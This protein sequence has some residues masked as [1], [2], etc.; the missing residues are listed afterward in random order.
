MRRRAAVIAAG[1]C[2]AVSARAAPNLHVVAVVP[3]EAT[4]VAQDDAD[5]F[6]D[7]L[8]AELAASGTVSVADRRVMGALLAR[9]G[10]TATKLIDAERAAAFAAQ[11]GADY[12]AVGKLFAIGTAADALVTLIGVNPVTASITARQAESMDALM[13]AVPGLCAELLESMADGGNA[14]E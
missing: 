7:R 5:A 9:Q 12:L 14:V 1:L 6:A 11:A 4:F 10:L 3:F 2:A 8:A 13:A